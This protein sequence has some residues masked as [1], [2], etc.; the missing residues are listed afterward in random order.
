MPF[1]IIRRSTRVGHRPRGALIG[2]VTAAVTLLGAGCAP[3]PPTVPPPSLP[4][5]VGLR[6]LRDVGG[7]TDPSSG[8]Y[9]ASIDRY[10]TL[11]GSTT[12]PTPA[13]NWG[14]DVMNPFAAAGLAN[15]GVP[16]L[17]NGSAKFPWN[18]FAGEG[19]TVSL[20][21]SPAHY[22]VTFPSGSCDFP[23]TSLGYSLAGAAPSPDGTMMAMTEGDASV[24]FRSTS[25]VRIVTLV[26]GACQTITAVSYTISD[27]DP[28]TGSD[29]R[30]PAIVWSPSSTAIIYR[31]DPVGS[32]ATS[33]I[34]LDAVSGS[35]PTTVLGAADGCPSSTPFGWS[36]ADRILLNC[37]RR[38]GE[39]PSSI[40]SSIESMPV[41][42]GARQVIDSMTLGAVASQLGSNAYFHYGYY[43]PGTTTIAFSSGSNTVTNS[44]GDA[45]PWLQVR[46]ISDVPGAVSGPILGVAPPLGWHQE[47][48]GTSP[49]PPFTFVD[50]P[51]A[52]L[53]ERFVH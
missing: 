1:R 46:V 24:G 6:W 37:T 52:E 16:L 10:Q 38:I 26:P 4:Q 50:V 40:V 2:V 47:R 14:V 20:V 29:A 45:F 21:P 28:P 34:R 33:V 27:L 5:D 3:C 32:D 13:A 25:S 41:A 51:N 42:G 11:A 43:V 44:A 48:V 19:I 53:V 18:G 39:P 23:P 31:L 7:T 8:I 9:V 49:F 36:V 30:D 22:R 17:P 12:G 15:I 35:A